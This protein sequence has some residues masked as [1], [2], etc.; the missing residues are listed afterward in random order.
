MQ[1]ADWKVFE[2]QE[3]RV[4]PLKGFGDVEVREIYNTGMWGPTQSAEDR[5]RHA[6]RFATQENR[7][8]PRWDA[9]H[10]AG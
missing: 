8:W 2:L 4:E 6:I 7:Y 3:A 9:A 10:S 1:P 5:A